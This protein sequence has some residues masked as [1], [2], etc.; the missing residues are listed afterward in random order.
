MWV[1][2]TPVRTP[3]GSGPGWGH[4]DG[5]G[6]E[7]QEFKSSGRVAPISLMQHALAPWPL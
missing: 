2:G 3:A 1:L 6:S 4:V 5:R 7:V